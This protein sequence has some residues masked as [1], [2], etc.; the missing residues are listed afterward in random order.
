[1]TIATPPIDIDHLRQWIDRGESVED[2]VTV[3]PLRALAATLDRDDALPTAG[4]TVPACW[5][6]LYFLPANRQSEIGP[7]GHPR[8]GEFLPPVLLPRR[9]SVASQ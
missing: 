3:A 9:M 4:D 6:W 8:R 7:D 5:H 1:M 2:V